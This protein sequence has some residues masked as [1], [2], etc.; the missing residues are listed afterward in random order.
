MISLESV[1]QPNSRAVLDRAWLVLVRA[2]VHLGQQWA[3][4]VALL[5]GLP[6]ALVIYGFLAGLGWP[7]QGWLRLLGSLLCASPTSPAG[8]WG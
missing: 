6:R 5:T 2:L 3:R 4:Q 8:L 7:W 1:G